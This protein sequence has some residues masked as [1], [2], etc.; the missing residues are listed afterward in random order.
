MNV[1]DSCL[2]RIRREIPEP[3]LK[4]AFAPPG[5]QLF[6]SASSIDEEIRKKVFLD[7]VLPEISRMGQ[8]EELDLGGLMYQNDTQDYY[9]RVYHI[10]ESKTGG[11]EIVA[12]HIAVTPVAGQAYTLPPAGSYLNGTTTGTLASTQQVVDSQSAMPRIASPEI[13][14]LGPNVIRI[15]DPGMFVYATKIMVKFSLSED[16]NEI[17]PAFYGI[18][19]DIMLYATRQYIYNKLMFD[20]DFGMLDNGMEFGA[21]KSFI[22]KW[23]DAGDMFN[24][25]LPAVQR[26]LVHN[27]TI[28]NRYNYMSGGRFKS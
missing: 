23:E 27:D 6:R 2:R 19:A 17:K 14:V 5:V 15:K 12:A 25:T 21:Y 24:D 9:S 3:I 13:R 1:F 22:E 16:L 20:M 7:F 4:A 18:I 10:D 26:A 28:G 11:R 8:Y